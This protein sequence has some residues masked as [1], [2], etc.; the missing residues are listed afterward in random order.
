MSADRR[1]QSWAAKWRHRPH[2]FIANC[3]AL[4]MFPE[5]ACKTLTAMD[6]FSFEPSNFP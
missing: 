6:V 5:I 4:A 2:L 1:K 3:G